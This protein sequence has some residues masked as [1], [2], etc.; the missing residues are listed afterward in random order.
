MMVRYWLQEWNTDIGLYNDDNSKIDKNEMKSLGHS[1]VKKV[2]YTFMQCKYDLLIGLN[3][4]QT[5]AKTYFILLWLQCCEAQ[6]TT[7]TISLFAL[8]SS[9]PSEIPLNPSLKA[10]GL[11]RVLLFTFSLF[12]PSFLASPLL[13][14]SHYSLF[15]GLFFSS[16]SLIPWTLTCNTEE[17]CKQTQ[18]CTPK[19]KPTFMQMTHSFTW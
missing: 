11:W 15:P 3:Q 17:T 7:T 6:I 1:K 4:Y 12:L 16:P 8:S 5:N 10:W 14:L 18:P 2:L 19:H 13:L 9:V